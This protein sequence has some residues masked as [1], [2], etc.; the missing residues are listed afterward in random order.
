MQNAEKFSISF[1]LNLHVYKYI[2]IS[3][4]MFQLFIFMN[5]YKQVIFIEVYAYVP[6]NRDK[7]NEVI[8]ITASDMYLNIFQYF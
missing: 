1:G 7:S 5:I 6:Y 8:F 2:S 3:K 4:H